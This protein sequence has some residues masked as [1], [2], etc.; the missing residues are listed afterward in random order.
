MKSLPSALNLAILLLV[1]LAACAPRSTP[2][3]VQTEA[4]TQAETA[5][6]V[7]INLLPPVQVSST[8]L[9]WDGTTLVAVPAGQFTMGH[10]G[11]D[12]PVHQVTLSDFWIYSTK[13]TNQQ[14]ALC[15]KVGGCQPPD[16]INDLGYADATHANDPVVGVTWEN[17]QVYCALVHGHL[18]TEA[19]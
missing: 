8:F 13:V 10:G 17:A 1:V 15:V 16:A 14:Y 9:Y 19:Q 12:N 18:P 3:T 11:L 6:L 5:T 7:P 4:A 2:A